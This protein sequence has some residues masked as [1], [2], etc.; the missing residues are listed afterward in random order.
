MTS[1]KSAGPSEISIFGTD[2]AGRPFSQTARLAR[3]DGFEVTIEGVERTLDVNNIVG[4]RHGGEKARFRVVWVGRKG[5]PQQGQLG[6]RAVDTGKDIFAG[7]AAAEPAPS[8][9][10]R[11]RFPRIQCHGDVRFRREGSEAT[12]SGALTILSEGGCY[13]QTAT[14]FPQLAHLDLRMNVEQMELQSI[15]EVHALKPGAGMGIAFVEMNRTDRIRLHEW[16]SQHSR[17]DTE[18]R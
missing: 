7:A 15:G 6:L 2:A 14:T 5:T 8:G 12:V 13:I 17:H 3:I 16:V 10:E 9:R 4:L 1:A 18:W 11:R